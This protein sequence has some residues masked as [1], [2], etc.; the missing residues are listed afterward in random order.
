MPDSFKEQQSASLDARLRAMIVDLSCDPSDDPTPILHAAG[1]TTATTLAYV[2][3]QNDPHAFPR[4]VWDCAEP[5][6]LSPLAFPYTRQVD[7][8]LKV[9]QAC[10]REAAAWAAVD[11]AIARR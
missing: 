9:W 8:L 6:V 2:A 3:P 5:G 7:N 10:A 11:S 4:E 1:L